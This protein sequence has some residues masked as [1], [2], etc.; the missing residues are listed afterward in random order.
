L[1]P[2]AEQSEPARLLAA[3]AGV[4]LFI[5]LL[6][7][8]GDLLNP[9]ILFWALLAVLLPFRNTPFFRPVVGTAGV[10]TLLWLLRE[11]GFLL[12]PFALAAV[13]AYI[14][15][16]VVRWTADRRFLSRFRGTD[17]EPGPARALAIGI[18]ALPV[19]GGL[20]GLLI[21]GIPYLG[22]ELNQMLA[23]APEALD[24]I[25]DF[26]SGLEERLARINLPGVDGS[27]WVER[28]RDLDG[29]ELVAFLQERSEGMGEAIWEGVLGLGR[30]VWSF[31]SILGYLVLAP[32]VAFYLLRDW[33]RIL[34]RL[35]SLVPESRGSWK[36]AAREY[37]RLLAAYLRGQ[38]TV[39]LSVGALTAAGLLLVQFPYAILLGAIVAV[40]N[41]VPYL[42]LVLSLLPALGIALA[43][44]TV[45]LS[46]LKVAV[47][48]T[49]AQT[50]ESAVISPR[51]VGDSTGLH[52]VWILFAI[53]TGG[54]FFGF[55]GL[56]LAVPAAVGVKLAVMRL[57]EAYRKSGF[58][59]SAGG[60]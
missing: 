11:M 20:A 59:Q 50:V 15:N 29:D 46:L 49:V 45:G 23:R 53:L 3:A 27:E 14:L 60:V 58:F 57:M 36:E 37:D 8:M 34:D 26:L 43:S 44:G 21:W 56:L 35:G 48:Y 25:A 54:F 19:V 33:E 51:I 47:V 9:F 31:L 12:A 18:L 52:P 5:L 39:S 24:R 41:V 38:V 16:P 32:V 6:W 30:G 55:V 28:L 40:F 1:S 17:E 4:A 10:L 42:G 13:A 22:Q 7:G 2:P